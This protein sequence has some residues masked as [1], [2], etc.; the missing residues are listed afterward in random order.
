ME[1]LASS[2]NFECANKY[3]RCCESNRMEEIYVGYICFAVSAIVSR[4]VLQFSN[5]KK[6]REIHA[7][8]NS[9]PIKYI[10]PRNVYDAIIIGAGP[11]GSTAAYYMGLKG[12]KVALIDKKTFPRHKPCGDAWCKPALD[13]LEEMNIL[14]KMEADG[15]TNPVKRGGFISPYGYKCINTDGDSYG[16]V[17]GC[18]TYAIKRYIADEYIVKAATSWSN[19]D[20]FPST[21]V[22]DVTFLAN[23]SSA[24]GSD[25]DRIGAPAGIWHATTATPL[26]LNG[27]IC[28]VCDGST[29][30][31]AQKVRKCLF[32]YIFI[33]SI[34]KI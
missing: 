17:T 31:L 21:E 1:F 27:I 22:T 25:I 9:V 4:T 26:T 30:Y 6:Q 11:A 33:W 3:L 29:S 14:Q 5:I 12:M 24:D 16:S 15:I 7:L 23:A 8:G 34:Y 10:A 32:I 20:Y 2:T 13:L 19:V 18:K 28:L